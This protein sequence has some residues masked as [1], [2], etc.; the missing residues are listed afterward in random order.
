M[1]QLTR[2]EYL[3]ARRLVRGNGRFYALRVMSHAA[4]DVMQ[5]LLYARED[6]LANREW[7]VTHCTQRGERYHPAETTWIP[8]SRLKKLN[9]EK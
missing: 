3:A 8:R 1:H 9:Q 6:V 5:R 4:R 7:W 2:K